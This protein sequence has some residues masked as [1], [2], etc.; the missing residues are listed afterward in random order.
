MLNIR[1]YQLLSTL[2]NTPI[3]T[4]PIIWATVLY[5]VFGTPFGGFVTL[6]PR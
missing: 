2:S 5:L 3:N 4:H 1:F 6:L